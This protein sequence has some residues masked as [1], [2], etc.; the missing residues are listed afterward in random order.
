MNIIIVGGGASGVLL[1]V[2]LL[3]QSGAETRMTLIEQRNDLGVGLAYST[4]DP[5]H[6]LNVRAQ[7]MSAFP[8]DPTHFQKWL[9]AD[10]TRA[11][12][13][14]SDTDFASRVD[15]GRYLSS[16]VTPLVEAGLKDR[17]LTIVQ[18]ECI[19]VAEHADGVR[20]TLADQTTITGDRLVLATGNEMRTTHTPF[21]R[22]PWTS[23]L[24]EDA[25]LSKDIA[26]LGSG[27]SMVDT[28]I[29]LLRAGYE[30][31][32]TVLSRHGFLPAPHA[33]TPPWPLE[34][35]QVPLDQGP[36]ACLR[37]LRAEVRRAKIAGADWRSVIDSLRPFVQRLWMSFSTREKKRFYIHLR[38]YWDIHR[39]R[40]APSIGQE[41]AAAR[42]SGELE[43]LAGEFTGAAADDGRIAFTF[44]RRGTTTT[45][46]RHVDR[47]YN[48][49]GVGLDPS[50]STAPLI[51]AL[52]EAGLVRPDPVG[53]GIDVDEACAVINR[54]GRASARLY[55]MGPQTRSRFWE[56]TAIPDIRM[57]ATKLA[58]Q[59]AAVSA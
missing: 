7:N 54:D 25:R 29:S 45:E 39:H 58:H 13:P 20:A 26:I 28:V 37:W 48:C 30:G 8:D 47:A 57:Q 38:P 42:A 24:G 10:T 55:A 41:I 5:A 14:P 51:K 1:A 31:R 59:L 35:E 6:L 50:K 16:L 40:M 32:I 34:P 56:V 3:K 9:A 52:V 15:F 43:I 44:R 53:L 21:L 18:G 27:L 19:A 23:P 33:L 36:L 4:R 2:N 12:T 22:S 17:L 11:T 49:T 46:T